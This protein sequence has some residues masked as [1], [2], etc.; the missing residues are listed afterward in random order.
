MFLTN[1]SDGLTDLCLPNLM[2]HYLKG[3]IAAFPAVKP[4]HSFHA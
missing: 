2:D 3:K 4:Q 1:Y